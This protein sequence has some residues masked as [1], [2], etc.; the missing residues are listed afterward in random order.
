[1]VHEY[2]DAEVITTPDAESLLTEE[3]KRDIATGTP[4]AEHFDRGSAANRTQ[5]ICSLGWSQP[6]RRADASRPD[7]EHTFHDGG[8]TADRGYDR[9]AVEGLGDI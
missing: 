5:K 4:S 3:V 9:V 8:T 2:R 7:I 6:G 1:L